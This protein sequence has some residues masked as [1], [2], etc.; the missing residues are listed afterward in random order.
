MTPAQGQE[1]S[2]RYVRPSMLPPQ[3]LEVRSDEAQ[4]ELLNALLAQIDDNDPDQ[5]KLHLEEL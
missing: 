1:E 2:R 4:G 3:V 5:I